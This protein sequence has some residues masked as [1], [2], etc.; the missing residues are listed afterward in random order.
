VQGVPAYNLLNPTD[1]PLQHAVAL[2][3]ANQK[4]YPRWLYIPQAT[5][6]ANTTAAMRRA[7]AKRM[8]T[9]D[10]SSVCPMNQIALYDFQATPTAGW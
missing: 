2:V 4:H 9:V 10:F 7:T 8:Y 3:M 6:L 1:T 5:C